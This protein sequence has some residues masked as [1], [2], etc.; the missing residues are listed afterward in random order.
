MLRDARYLHKNNGIKK[1]VVSLVDFDEVRM[2]KV[3]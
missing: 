2:K 1:N 3:E